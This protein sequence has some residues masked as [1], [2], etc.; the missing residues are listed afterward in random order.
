MKVLCF[1][2]MED[3]SVKKF[4]ISS[5]GIT[6]KEAKIIAKTLQGNRSLQKLDISNN[7][8]CDDGAVAIIKS[9]E[10]NSTLQELDISSNNIHGE[11]IAVLGDYLKNTKLHKL[12]IS[13]NDSRLAYVLDGTNTFCNMSSKYLTNTG[14]TLISAFLFQNHVIQKLD[15]S[16]NNMH[17]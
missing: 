10:N 6:S 8:M 2:D 16:H 13:W 11:G 5:H 17:I 15:L 9:L 1:C 4:D 14:V 7:N 3:N 12:T